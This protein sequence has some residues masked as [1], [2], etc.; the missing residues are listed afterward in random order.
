VCSEHSRVRR[1]AIAFGKNDKVA[2]HHR[3]AGNAF[4]IT[5]ADDERTRTGQI[6]QAF[7]NTLG[8]RFLND[9]DQNRG[10]RKNAEHDGFPEIA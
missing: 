2:A 3:G 9:G 10:A 1:H 8:T 6:A 4:L 5:V 7:E